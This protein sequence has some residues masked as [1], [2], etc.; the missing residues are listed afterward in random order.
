MARGVNMDE[1]PTSNTALEAASA[2]AQSFILVCDD[3]LA[4]LGEETFTELYIEMFM[5]DCRQSFSKLA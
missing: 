4:H 1:T 2:A 5:S 3:G